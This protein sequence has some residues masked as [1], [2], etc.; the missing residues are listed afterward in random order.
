MSDKFSDESFAA[1][2]RADDLDDCPGCGDPYMGQQRRCK[3][4]GRVFCADCLSDGCPECGQ[5]F[6]AMRDQN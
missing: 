5:L 3:Q 6:L 2:V 4:C 1:D